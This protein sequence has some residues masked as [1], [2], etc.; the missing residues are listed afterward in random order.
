[1]SYEVCANEAKS[2]QFRRSLFVAENVKAGE[3]FTNKNVR[4]VRPGHGLHP[5]HLGAVIGK[6]AARDLA[7]GTPLKMEDVK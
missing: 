4:S 6:R 2:R 7:L 5:R 3:M 1:V